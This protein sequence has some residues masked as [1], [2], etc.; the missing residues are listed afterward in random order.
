M[1]GK[2]LDFL[3]PQGYY[4]GV[5]LYSEKYECISKHFTLMLIQKGV[6]LLHFS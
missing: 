4:M 6:H 5:Q 2:T 3:F 1:L